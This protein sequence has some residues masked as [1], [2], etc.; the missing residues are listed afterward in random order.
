MSNENLKNRDGAVFFDEKDGNEKE[1]KETLKDKD[2]KE[3]DNIQ[4]NSH[5]KKDKHHKHQ[6]EDKTDYL[7]DLQRL[8]AEFDNFRKRTAKEKAQ[9]KEFVAEEIL[10]NLL[11]V[12]DNFN[13]A[14]ESFEKTEN[15]PSAFVEGV[16]MIYNQLKDVFKK[17]GVQEINAVGEKFNPEIHEAVGTEEAEEEGIVLKELQKGYKIGSR[18]IR[19]SSVIVSKKKKEVSSSSDSDSEN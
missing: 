8:Q 19:P 18:V 6:Q 12:F 17:Y 9:I 3:K 10:V 1:M 11:P 14:V 7:E 4:K 5:H 2:K 13:R 15:L 16:K